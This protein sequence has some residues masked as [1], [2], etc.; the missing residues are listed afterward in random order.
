MN[1]WLIFQY[2][3]DT[4]ET[5]LLGAVNS[6]VT[7]LVSYAAAPVQAAL[8]L[9]V[10]LTGIM[11]LRGNSSEA[12]D[13]ILGRV[14]KLCLVSWFATNGSVYT[15]WVQD[16]F[17]TALPNDLTNAVSNSTLGHGS[18]A[19]NSF[20]NLNIKAFN[21][22]L[23]VGKLLHWW[24]VAEWIVVIVFWVLSVTSVVIAF[25]IWLLSHVILALFIAIGPLMIGLVLFPVTRSIFERWIGA[26]ISCVV[27][28]LLVVILVAFM[29]VIETQAVGTIATYTG[30]NAFA[31]IQALMAAVVFFILTGIIAL[32]L[33]AMATSLAGGLQM[34]GAGIGR[35][36]AELATGGASR[37][38]QSV[39]QG[40]AGAAQG[41]SQGT[42]GLYQRIRPPTGGSLSNS[43]KPIR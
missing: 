43:P 9:Y 33:P 22:G 18:V 20:D 29:L 25:S 27:L 14:I 10:A 38:V 21:A 23:A 41:A 37:L 5:P 39:A 1:T 16:F 12:M 28:Q 6:I 7:G 35:K 13:G 40:G 4:L 2:I 31:Q 30:N 26:M 19:A 34:H 42:R 11:I 32:Q 15:T 24:D 8:V 3:F 17:L 36:A